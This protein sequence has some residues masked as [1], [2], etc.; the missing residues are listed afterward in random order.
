M[1]SNGSPP[2]Y[3]ETSKLIKKVVAQRVHYEQTKQ[4]V[5]NAKWEGMKLFLNFPEIEW[6]EQHNKIVKVGNKSIE[7]VPYHTLSTCIK[8]FQI[9][10]RNKRKQKNS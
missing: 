8:L 7:N 3:N 1:T 9:P 4:C 10:L 5:K 2:P 6:N